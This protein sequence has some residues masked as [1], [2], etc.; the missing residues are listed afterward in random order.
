ML[1]RRPP[2]TSVI[3]HHQARAYPRLQVRAPVLPFN[4]P[5]LPPSR[6][7]YSNERTAIVKPAGAALQGLGGRRPQVGARPQH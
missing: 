3:T 4:Q 2:C 6:S 7:S 5:P 1:E